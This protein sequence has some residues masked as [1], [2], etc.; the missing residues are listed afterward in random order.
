MDRQEVS[1]GYLLVAI[2]LAVVVQGGWAGPALGATGTTQDDLGRHMPAVTDAALFERVATAVH[3]REPAFTQM[4]SDLRLPSDTTLDRVE[5]RDSVVHLDLTLPSEAEEWSPSALEAEALAR[6]LAVAVQDDLDFGGVRVQVRVGPDG[7]YHLLEDFVESVEAGVYPPLKEDSEVP[8]RAAPGSADQERSGP[9]ANAGHQPTGALSGV[10]VFAAAGHGW[11]AGTSSWYLQRP[12]LLN[13]IE[14]YGNID[15]LNYFVNYLFNAGATVVPFRPIGYQDNEIV[16]DQDDPEVTYAGTWLDSTG[17][18][19]YENGRTASGV[20]YRYAPTSSTETATARYTP[21]I[22]E[23]GSYPVYTWL[24]DSDN[25]APQLYRIV[26]S[27]GTTEIIVDHRMVGKGW[28]WLGSYYFESGTGGYVEISDESSVL[29]KNVIADA[30]RFGN[31]IGDVVGGGPGTISGYPRDEEGQRYWAESETGDNAVGMSSTIYDLSGSNDGSDNVGTA[32]RWAREMNNTTTNNDRWRRIY[33]EYHTNAGGGRGTVALVT[34]NYTTHQLDYATIL[35]DEIEQ[36]MQILDSG[37]EHT[38]ISRYNPYTASFGAISTTNN[39]NEFD[40]TILEVAFH[41]SPEDTA[42]L[43]DPKV[44]NAVARSTV[45]GMIKFLNGIP[46]STIPL[47]FLPTEPRKV[48]AAHNGSGGVVVAWQAPLSGEAYGDAATGYRVYRSTNGYG[49][50]GGTDVGN[51]LATTLLDVPAETTT[52]VRVA[53][54]NAGGES[55]PSETVAVRRE[56]AGPAEILVVNGF[57]RVSRQQDPAH[58]LS[59]VGTQLRPILGRVNSF[60]YVIQHAEAL[61]DAGVTFDTCANENVI[62]GDVTLSTYGAVVWISGE[63]S[64][65]FDTFNATEQSLVSAYCGGGGNIFA[66][67]SE[68]AYDLDYL[69][70]GRSFY[71]NYLKGDYVGD[72]ADTYS[73]AAQA[74]SIFAGISSFTFDDGAL[75][76]NVNSPDRL[77]VSGGST[78][79]LSYSGGTG[80]TA[81]VVY[82]GA[83]RAVTFG[84]PFETIT[85]AA[86]RA[87]VMAAIVEFFDITSNGPVP[88]E[89]IVESRDTGGAVTPAPTY[90]E[91]G[92]WASND[93]VK[94]TVAGLVGLGSRYAEYTLPTPGTENT[95][96]V[97]TLAA[98]GKY[99]VFG[100]WGNEANCRDAR[101]SVRHHHGDTE[102]E[103]DQMPDT[104]GM[105]SNANR[106]VSLGEYWFQEGQNLATASVNLSVETVSDQPEPSY[107]PRV[108][109]DAIRWSPIR[110]WPDGDADGDNDVDLLDFAT[111]PACV[112]GPG[113]GLNQPECE[114]FDLDVDGDVD[115]ADFSGFQAALSAS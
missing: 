55:M 89:I 102:L 82:D 42:M 9:V 32:A 110:A 2:L 60:D 62:D 58:T 48:R 34:G 29:S 90:E 10:T 73:V 63:E 111:F 66:S 71:N 14:D 24:L 22:P 93:T 75:F 96:F 101:F 27:G 47:D 78:V 104:F 17:S 79:G 109:A 1:S 35:G 107:A 13:M 77:N 108:Y 20:H 87:D 44:R 61:A 70:N 30:I 115:L 31:G 21:D 67:G 6:R 92:T 98:A 76:Y 43:L 100:T 40:A 5:V 83:F 46:S 16:L 33:M 74:G 59:G 45:H 11:T 49:F 88:I 85:S 53:A 23:A 28:V 64:S 52:Y 26:H 105:F 86:R 57:D 51:M 80:G 18:P 19:Y 81:G 91:S 112:S 39:S 65:T 7:A 95:D 114:E 56:A 54:Y 12:L 15:Q 4:G 68:I 8:P 25:R 94:S 84:F 69:N 50:D 36:D 72:D 3:S 41:D 37:F 38:W 97:P 113:G 99:E 103:I 106:W